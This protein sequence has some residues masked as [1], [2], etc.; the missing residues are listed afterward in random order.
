ME[1]DLVEAKQQPVPPLHVDCDDELLVKHP[2]PPPGTG[3]PA[4][5][6]P[7]PSDAA[8]ISRVPPSLL[9]TKKFTY[10]P[11]KYDFVS[12]VRAI[13][14]PGLQEETPL[15]HLH[16]TPAGLAYL[17]N[18]KAAHSGRTAWSKLWRSRS[19]EVSSPFRRV[20]GLF[21]SEVLTPLLGLGP[22][23]LV[24]YQRSP[25]LR[26]HLSHTGAL[27]SRH[28]DYGYKRQPTEINCWLPLTPVLG[29][30][31]LWSE[32]APGKGDFRPFTCKN[33]GEAYLFHGSQNEHYT[34]PN[35]TDSTR[36]SLDF[37]I[38]PGI[39]YVEDYVAPYSREGDDIPRFIRG[40]AYTDTDAE[41]EWREPNPK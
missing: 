10:D 40:K 9:Q 17:S 4:P 31:T 1:S 19:I 7:H 14:T 27:G 6:P 39:Y 5:F 23:D 34:L 18:K 3:N 28:R 37:R 29:S 24:V 11:V 35:K 13:I 38:I 20:L 15:S 33:A 8:L 26:I 12:T 30:N 41:R 16:L 36:V 32:S 21:V 25:T 2:P 22:G